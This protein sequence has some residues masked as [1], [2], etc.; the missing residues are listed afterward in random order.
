MQ[1]EWTRWAERHG[2]L[3]GLIEDKDAGMLLELCEHFAR[4]GHTP[5]ELTE[6]T[7]WLAL[8]APP[9][10]RTEHLAALQERLR[11]QRRRA[12]LRRPAAEDDRG[13]CVDCRGT[14][15]V[16]V[17]TLKAPPG[18]CVTMAVVCGCPLGRSFRQ[19]NPN[20]LT[21]AQYELARPD[22]RREVREQAER[23]PREANA[24]R[25]AGDLDRALGPVLDRARRAAGPLR[26][27][28]KPPEPG[29]ETPEPPDAA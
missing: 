18:S 14:A 20:W 26:L 27:P 19:R 21:L 24:A 9:R 15:L 29:D 13:A 8:N 28:P 5:A 12:G 16:S 22:W 11:E 25:A 7:E 1:E 17:P 10:F 4:Q 2:G 23:S 6:A 3:F